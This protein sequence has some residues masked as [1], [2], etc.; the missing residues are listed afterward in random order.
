MLG[1]SAAVTVPPGLS[2]KWDVTWGQWNV[3]WVRP[4]GDSCVREKRPGDASGR[5]DSAIATTWFTS[6][7]HLG[8][9][10]VLGYGRPFGNVKEMNRA[11]C[12]NW[13][14]VI[15]PDD[16]VWILGD[17]ARG[18]RLDAML[19]L[20]SDLPGHKHLV[21]G[22]HDRCWPFRESYGRAEV[23]RYAQAGFA[24]IVT[25]ADVEI[26]GEPVKLSHFPYR[27]SGR[28]RSVKP[29]DEGGWLVHGHIHKAWLQKGRQICV[30]VD[31][32]RYSPVHISSLEVLIAAGPNDLSA[33]KAASS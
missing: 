9:N 17:L 14:N 27:P 31:A 32:W 33:L 3:R 11:L 4:V 28:Q 2:S 12:E 26:G 8:D 21:T 22:N 19:K 6:D 16:E 25:E 7:L 30:A 29:K 24:S 23:A 1:V 13:R 5:R 18:S 15:E 20:V 10:Q